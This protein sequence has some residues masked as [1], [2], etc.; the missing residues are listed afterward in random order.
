MCKKC[1]ILII[2]V[3][4]GFICVDIAIRKKGVASYGENQRK[5]HCVYIGILYAGIGN[6]Y[7]DYHACVGGGGC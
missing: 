1:I 2:G 6:L 5:D 3:L 7:G 4:S